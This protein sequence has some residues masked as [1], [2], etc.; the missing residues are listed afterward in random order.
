MKLLI[1]TVTLLLGALAGAGGVYVWVHGAMG[2]DGNSDGEEILYYRHP[3][4]SSITSQTPDKDSMGMDYIPVYAGDAGDSGNDGPGMVS[5]KPQVAQNLGVRKA[6]ARRGDL[7]PDIHALGIIH[8]DE[9]GLEHTHV[10]TEAWV[11]DLQVRTTG[12]AVKQGQIL[13]RIDS[14][15]LINAQEEFLQAYRRNAGA[16]SARNRLRILGM[17]EQDIGRIE[18]T[19]QSMKL[20]PVRAR[21]GGVVRELNI[22]EGMFVQPDSTLMTIADLSRVWVLLELF[23]PDMDLLREGQSV[24]ITLPFRPDSV[25]EA[26]VDYIYP[27]LEAERR[28]LQARV[29]LENPDGDLHPG[30]FVRAGV[31]V[32]PLADVVHVPAESVIRTGRNDRLVVAL[33]DGG[34]Q[35]REVRLGRRVGDRFEI[36]EGVEAGETV[37]VSGQFLIDSESSTTAGLERLSQGEEGASEAAAGNEKEPVWTRGRIDSLSDDGESATLTHEPVPEWDWPGMTM[38]FRLAPDLD[39]ALLQ[40]GRELRFRVRKHPQKGYEITAIEPDQESEGGEGSQSR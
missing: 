30:M 10:R 35:V 22:A 36:L 17:A 33:E 29:V 2:G 28:V 7:T 27:S 19:G 9:S 6:D 3:M 37:V 40:E 21:R 13:F 5:I 18:K 31:R 26:T 8:Y 11:E 34:F 4:D 14:P 23:E 16:D 32:E 1:L 38:P 12:A 20:V 15:R 25:H 39:P 24:R